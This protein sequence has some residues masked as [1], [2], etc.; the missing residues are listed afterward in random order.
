MNQ[1]LIKYINGNIFSGLVDG[2]R[3]EYIATKD[4]IILNAGI[5]NY[6]HFIASKTKVID[7]NNKFVVPGFMDNHTHF[8]SGGNLLMSIDLHSAKSKNQFMKRFNSYTKKIN[9]GE[10]V[11]GGNWDHENWG[12]LLPDKSWIDPYTNK[13][14]VLV[15]RVDG[16]MAL[17]NT[18][19]L[20]IS[21]IT[22]DT[23]NPVGGV[24]GKDP[25]TGLPTGILK[26]NAIRLVSINIPENSEEKRNVFL[27]LQ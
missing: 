1:R 8:M 5:G 4:N 20:E 24:I 16:H 27:I 6:E 7:L 26:D 17:A 12:G 18:V 2:K 3:L 10:W 19:A 13:N 21:G 25:K 15:S 14:P 9:A 23:P 11:T 22:K